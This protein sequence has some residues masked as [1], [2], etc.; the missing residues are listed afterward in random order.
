MC[1]I[2]KHRREP[3]RPNS[4]QQ[5]IVKQKYGRSEYL[6]NLA[7]QGV[8]GLALRLPYAVRVRF[9]GW[10]MSAIAAP[11]AGWRTRI[12]MN[13]KLVMPDM[14]RKEVAHMVRAVPD[15]FGRAL[16][17]SYSGQAFLD[18]MGSLPLIGPGV[19]AL[20]EAKAAKRPV[21][22]ATGHFGNYQASRAALIAK[23][24]PVG[25]LYMPMS[26][27]YFND[28]YVGEMKAFGPAFERS[29][30]GLADMVKFL[31]QGGMVG[32][33]ADHYMAHG[34]PIEFMGHPAYTALSAAEMA[35]KYDAAVIPVYSRRRADGLLFDIIVDHPIPH[36]DPI[37]MTR[38]MNE[39]LETLVK[40]TPDQWFWI[41]R[42]WK[43]PKAKAA[44]PD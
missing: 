17:E 12:R 22:L 15:N 33:V 30:R 5:S 18:R 44:T 1:G 42:R 32:V 10:V 34:E 2:G 9:I 35:L 11:L 20:E 19:A 27:G 8:I 26:N 13:L 6:V 3:Y 29:R 39:S 25:V 31:R 24:Y 37:A 36:G 40:E 43:T 28:R 14:T 41:H 4:N 16:I 23:G 21:V 38:A 7:I